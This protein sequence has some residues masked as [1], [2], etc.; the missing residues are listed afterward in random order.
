MI[1]RL[2]SVLKHTYRLAEILGDDLYATSAGPKTGERLERL[3]GYHMSG[4]PVTEFDACGFDFFLF[5]TWPLPLSLLRTRFEKHSACAEDRGNKL[6]EADDR[7]L[8]HLRP[9]S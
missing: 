6:G 8:R 1:D 3:Y 9:L 2:V 5:R 7:R 4:H